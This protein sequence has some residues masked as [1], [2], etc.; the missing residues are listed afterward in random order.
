MVFKSQSTLSSRNTHLPGNQITCGFWRLLSYFIQE[1]SQWLLDGDGKASANRYSWVGYDRP[2][3]EVWTRLLFW[4]IPEDRPQQMTVPKM[5]LLGHAL[6]KL[7]WAHC[8]VAMLQEVFALTLKDTFLASMDQFKEDIKE[9]KIL[10]KKLNS[11]KCCNLSLGLF[12]VAIFG[13]FSAHFRLHFWIIFIVWQK[14]DIKWNQK[15]S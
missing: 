10:R 6:V 3:W 8:K 15:W 11:K 9:Y 4:C 14:N 13:P 2:W 5:N 12:T 1:A 7:G